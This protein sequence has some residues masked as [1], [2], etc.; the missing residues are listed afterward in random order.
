MKCTDFYQLYQALDKVAEEELIKAV[1]AHKGVYVF[2]AED[3]EDRDELY[4]NCPIVMGSRHSGDEP[5]P[6]F[7]MKV[8]VE[9]SKYGYENIHI[10]G[11]P[12]DYNADYDEICEVEHGHLPNI[13]D[14]IPEIDNMTDVSSEDLRHS[15]VS[16]LSGDVF[17]KFCY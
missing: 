10:Y 9:Y 6:Y 5:T 4:G 8:E 7:V 2:A 17:N 13:I 1:K 14:F 15:V 11:I 12:V 3:Q 16:K